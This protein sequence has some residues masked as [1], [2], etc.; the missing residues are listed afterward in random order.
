MMKR[1]DPKNAA[2]LV[3]MDESKQGTA[4]EVLEAQGLLADGIS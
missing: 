3:T 1:I 4:E 2:P